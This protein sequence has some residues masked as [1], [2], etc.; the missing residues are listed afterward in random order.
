[1]NYILV[2]YLISIYDDRKNLKK[3]IDHYKQHDP[4]VDHELLICFKNFNKNDPIFEIQELKELK[5]TK[6]FDYKNYNDY[7]WGS[8]RRIA[9]N[10]E[11]KII[12]FMNCHSFPIVNNWLKIFIDNYRPKTLLGPG[13]SNESMVQSAL[14]GIHS[15]KKFKSFLYALSNFVDFPLFP[16]PHIRSNCFMLSS[17]DFLNLKLSNKYRFNKKGT[18]INESGRNGMTNQLKKKNFKVFVVNAEGKLFDEKNWIKSS[19]YALN[20]QK[21]LIVSDKFSRIYE[22]LSE[23]E[24][25]K[26]TKLVWGTK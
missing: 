18:W 5:F 9:S 3:F 14:N 24:K 6:F 11:D 13:A 16:N 26:Y 15:N 22:E 25:F 19:T 12:F 7:D 17:K 20:N 8:Y 4:G 21:K 1:M 23:E 2:V 10:F